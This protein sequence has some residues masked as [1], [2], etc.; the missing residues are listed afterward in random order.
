MALVG[1]CNEVVTLGVL[2]GLH[3]PTPVRGLYDQDLSEASLAAAGAVA[4]LQEKRE[5]WSGVAPGDSAASTA[6]GVPSISRALIALV[7]MAP[8]HMLTLPF[9]RGVDR[10][11]VAQVPAVVAQHCYSC[12]VSGALNLEDAIVYPQASLFERLLMATP[13]PC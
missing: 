4:D 5:P 13:T 6:G 9:I 7:H 10:F 2:K 3:P 12:L 1:P 8:S 11:S